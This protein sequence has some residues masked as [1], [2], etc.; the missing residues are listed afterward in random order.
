M[1]VDPRPVAVP[2]SSAILALNNAHRVELSWVDPERFGF[3]VRQSFYA[4]T[5]GEAD[6]FLLAFDQAAHYDS[7]NY[8]WFRER[9]PRFVYID[10]VDIVTSTALATILG[11]ILPTERR[12]LP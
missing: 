3:L 12:A 9:L 10:R 8:L 4:R 1:S 11:N 7:P 5:V 6:A 2:V